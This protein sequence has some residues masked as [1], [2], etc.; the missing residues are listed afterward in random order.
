MSDHNSEDQNTD[1]QNTDDQNT[2]PQDAL[3]DMSYA[4]LRDLAFSIAEHRLDIGFFIDLMSHT[5]A[6]ASVADEGGSL[7]DIS[8]SLLETIH[9]AK[10]I[11]GA[12]SL[13]EQEPLFRARYIEYIREHR[14]A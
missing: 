7:G 6:I 3:E 4:E 8:G 9:A 2:A 11:F 1:D 5:T 13:G 10:Q 14:S 12:E